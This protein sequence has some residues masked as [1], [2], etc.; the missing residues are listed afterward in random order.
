MLLPEI[1]D[2]EEKLASLK[3]T[4][5]EVGKEDA[6]LKL[7]KH[8]A[9]EELSF[10]VDQLNG[11]ELAK[12]KFPFL[13]SNNNILY[14]PSYYLEQTSSETT[15]GFKAGIVEGDVLIDMT[16]GFGIDTFFFSQKIRETWYVEQDPLIYE[17]ASRNLRELNPAVKTICGDSLQFLQRFS[18]KAD[19]I[20][21]DP[22]R[23]SKQGRL[24]RVEEY[25][26]NI[27]A[28]REQLFRHADNVM[29]KL[30]PMTDISQLVKL[31]G[32]QIDHVYVLAV[33]N[34]CRELLITADGKEHDNPLV[35]T[36][37]WGKGKKE[38]FISY[39]KRDIDQPAPT[40][41]DPLQYLY[42]PN[43]AVFKAQQYDELAKKYDLF[44]LH[45]N[46]HIYTADI[47]QQ[48][49][50]GRIYKVHGVY[51]FDAKA[52]KSAGDDLSFNI[53]TRNFP[54]DPTMVAKKLRIKDGGTQF[55]FCVKTKD[56][57]L[58]VVVGKRV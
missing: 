24:S 5:E 14:P 15:A 57:K 41:S 21:L 10:L 55:L 17:I 13:A 20:F 9:Q 35:E 2:I 53:K 45:P 19:W 25:Q 54:M 26:P 18:K 8:F 56:E 7:S 50:P 22:L 29:I 27:Y 32:N 44:K 4:V 58:R 37:N 33:D 34:E 36:I 39:L 43:A 52:L 28:I 46:T 30:S 42:E 31:L 38:S 6:I 1:D 49:Y 48:D 12:E 40:L 16:G 47:Y 3:Q 51:A 23:R 11:R